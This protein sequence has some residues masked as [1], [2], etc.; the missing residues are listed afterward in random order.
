MAA[1]RRAQEF[2]EPANGHRALGEPRDVL[3]VNGLEGRRRSCRSPL[4]RKPGDPFRCGSEEILE[5]RV[6]HGG[7]SRRSGHSSAPTWRSP[8]QT[9]TR[10]TRS[11]QDDR[12]PGQGLVDQRAPVDLGPTRNAAQ[13][14]E[15]ALI[16]LSPRL[17]GGRGSEKA[18]PGAGPI[19]VAGN[20]L[21]RPWSDRTTPGHSSRRA[22]GNRLGPNLAS[23]RGARGRRTP[24]PSFLRQSARGS[25]TSLVDGQQPVAHESLGL[26]SL[27]RSSSATQPSPLCP[28]HVLGSVALAPVRSSAKS[29]SPISRMLEERSLPLNDTPSPRTPGPD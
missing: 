22:G 19:E 5:S 10:T 7:R 15:P 8:R 17:S 16:L 20:S 23:S 27:S 6:P 13:W 29:R 9:G 26:P 12:P 28:R 24:L 18:T 14:C 2:F 25:S 3:A 4:L 1:S 11:W 21:L